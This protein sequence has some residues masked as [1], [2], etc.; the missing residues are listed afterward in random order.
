MIEE[1]IYSAFFNRKGIPF[2][3]IKSIILS[4]LNKY[5][6]YKIIDYNDEEFINEI[7]N[8]Y[9]TE[10]DSNIQNNYIIW[11]KNLF[12]DYNY[13][14]QILRNNIF[15]LKYGNIK[16][17]KIQNN[18]IIENSINN[19]K[20][21]QQASYFLKISQDKFEENTNNGIWEHI[22]DNI[23]YIIMI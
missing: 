17:D 19:F 6:P 14:A 11:I 10:Y 13:F 18:I 23:T 20:T 9:L 2:E 15:Y 4:I 5:Y 12:H 1:L 21:I 16:I 3:K 22:I 8:E 7:I